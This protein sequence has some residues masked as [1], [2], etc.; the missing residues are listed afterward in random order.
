MSAIE[1][2]RARLGELGDLSR[3]AALLAWDERTMMPVAGGEAR[4]NQHATLGG[5]AGVV[6]TGWPTG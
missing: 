6:S 4:S 3:A 1:D 5:R 2:L